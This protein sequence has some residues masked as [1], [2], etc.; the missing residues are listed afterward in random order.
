MLIFVYDIG[1]A[2]YGAYGVSVKYSFNNNNLN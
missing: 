2:R 1:S